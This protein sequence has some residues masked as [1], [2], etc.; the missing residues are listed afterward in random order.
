MSND[1]LANEI[2]G[3]V[4]SW[5]DCVDRRVRAGAVCHSWRSV[6]R[7][8]GAV[9]RSTCLPKNLRYGEGAPLCAARSAAEA[10]HG[11]CLRRAFETHPVI[12]DLVGEIVNAAAR[13]DNVA[14]FAYV[15]ERARHHHEY[16]MVQAAE[17]GAAR[18]LAHMLGDIGAYRPS[19]LHRAFD[20]AVE[21]DHH[22]CVVL[23]SPH[24]IGDAAVNKVAA[25]GTTAMVDILVADGHPLQ[26]GACAAAALNGRLA[27]L[28]H[29]RLLGCPWDARTYA[30]AI[31]SGRSD[32]LTY[33]RDNG[34]PCDARACAAAVSGGRLALLDD[35]RRVGCPWDAEACVHAARRRDM[36][37]LV[38]LVENGCPMRAD[39]CKYAALN[40]DLD[41]LVY[42]REHGCPWHW[43]II[44][45]LA[46]ALC[47]IDHWSVSYLWLSEGV[48]DLYDAGRLACLAYAVANGCPSQG[49]ALLYAVEK[50]DMGM[51]VKMRG[52]GVPWTDAVTLCAAAAGRNAMVIYAHEDGCLWHPL[53]ISAATKRGAVNILRYALAHDCPYD[54]TE[55]LDAA[56]K[57]GQWRCAALLGWAALPGADILCDP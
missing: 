44:D 5:L 12:D 36:D 7:D 8:D 1:E 45:A 31:S 24:C 37:T 52:M 50:N 53:T 14:H 48:P 17:A 51:M 13:S 25:R 15:Y 23:L 34:C 27:M 56:R 22:Q 6:A 18:V 28:Q 2:L 10:I 43:S 49:D 46:F 35:L 33:V 41:M 40:G 3:L 19:F 38:Y 57:G 42:A 29:L 16:A 4:F 9:G 47:R 30:N 32:A 39:V 11:D 21:Y 20:K 54:E 26:Q 55:A